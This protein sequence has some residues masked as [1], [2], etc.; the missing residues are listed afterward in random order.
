MNAI[1]NLHSALAHAQYEGFGLIEY[2]DRD[3][4]HYN[5][6]REDKRV[7]KTRRHGAL[8]IEVYAMFAQTWGSTTLG[9]GGVGGQAMTTAYTIVL[10]SN[11]LGEYCVY[12]GGRFAYNIKRC[13]QKFLEHV[14]NQQLNAVANRS[15]YEQS[16]P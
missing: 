9:F 14:A 10:R 12:F 5:K 2:E 8:D 7:T 13:N 11:I 3:W 1:E 16:N 15:G 6:T 4:N